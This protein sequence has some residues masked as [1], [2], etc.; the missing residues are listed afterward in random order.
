M[1]T[2]Q[3]LKEYLRYDE[4]TGE[5]HWIKTKSNNIKVGGIAG[6]VFKGGRN[7]TLYRRTTVCGYR[8]MNHILVWLYFK[9]TLPVR[10]LDHIDGDGLNN[11]IGN[12]RECS[13]Q[14]NQANIGLR[15]DNTSG[16]RGVH[17]SKSKGLW[18][19]E[20]RWNGQRLRLGE[21][22]TPL[23]AHEAYTKKAIEI[24]GEFYK[25]V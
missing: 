22:K 10:Q 2:Q 12:L 23:L 11:R 15:K 13:G 5:L 6:T 3:L 18:R 14:E 17:F 25:E 9:G 4:D 7:N 8:K 19:A 20:L 24:H 1:L 16:Y 21:F